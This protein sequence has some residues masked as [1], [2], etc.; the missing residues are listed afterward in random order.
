MLERVICAI[1]GSRSADRAV[2]YAV[3]LAGQFGSE[4]RFIL[5]STVSPDSAARTHFWDE[6]LFGAGERQI[7]RE[8][9]EAIEAA[10]RAGLK[11]AS[12]VTIAGRDIA[13]AIIGYA[14]EHGFDHIVMGSAGHTALG[15]LLTGSVVS[16]VLEK[17]HPPVTVV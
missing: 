4:L 17:P 3:R 6:Q 13:S 2:D 1:D 10:E 15:R 5:V 14:R 7:A 9:T 11:G 8:L 16:D 12:A